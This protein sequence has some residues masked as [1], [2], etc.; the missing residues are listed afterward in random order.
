[1]PKDGGVQPDHLIA[2]LGPLLDGALIATD[3]DGT[4][5]PLQ[6][7]PDASRPVDRAVPALQA[8]SARG[9]EVAVITGRDAATVVRLGGLEAVPGLVVAGI[10][11]IETWVDGEVTTPPTPQVVERLREQLPAAIAGTDP[12]VWIEDKRLSLVV[13]ARR[14]KDPDAALAVVEPRVRRLAEE[15]GFEVHPGAQVLELRL[16]GFDKAGALERLAEGATAVLWLGDDVGDI[17]AFEHVRRMRDAGREAWG[18]AVAAS[19][20]AAAAE[21][22]DVVVPDAEAAATL[23]AGLA[24]YSASS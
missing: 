7:D 18:V 8:L 14:A 4:L 19:G 1:M 2:R 21:A 13:H 12:A 11:G 5:A 22:A 23:L 9:A 3:F 10:Y 24:A 20:V 16:P 15:L 17:P 6:P